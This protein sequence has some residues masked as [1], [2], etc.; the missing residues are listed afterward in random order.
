MRAFFRSCFA[1]LL[2]LVCANFAFAD[3][4]AKPN[5]YT[6]HDRLREQ[7]EW[8]RKTIVDAYNQVGNK[9]PAWDAD[10]NKFLD[11]A[12]QYFSTS[13]FGPI[14]RSDPPKLPQLI[15]LAE[16]AIKK[17]CD[18]PL[19]FYCY[20]A[21]LM[22]SQRTDEA[23]PV[24]QQAYKGLLASNS[25]WGAVPCSTHLLCSNAVSPNL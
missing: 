2:V 8:N 7:L 13:G 18:D 17:G 4:T 15:E 6:E 23:K 19:V 11:T 12:A 16:A 20:A 3:L 1:L 5:A 24:L 25:K 9:N 10:A 14:L 22:D 21:F